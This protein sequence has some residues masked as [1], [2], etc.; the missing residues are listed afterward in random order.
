VRSRSCADVI[1][2]HNDHFERKTMRTNVDGDN[3]HRDPS[4]NSSNYTGNYTIIHNH[5]SVKLY[6]LAG[7]EPGLGN[8]DCNEEL[9]R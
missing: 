2:V 4:S 3:L 5:I 9:L 6:E 1:H 8:G 7:F